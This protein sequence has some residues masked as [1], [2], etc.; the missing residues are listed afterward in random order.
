MMAQAFHPGPGL[1]PS[2][3]GV[4]HRV[5]FF[6]P[7]PPG[8]PDL[9]APH[10]SAPPRGPPSRPTPKPAP[11]PQ[12]QLLPF[13]GRSAE[14]TASPVSS[15]VSPASGGSRVVSPRCDQAPHDDQGFSSPV[16]V[17]AAPNLH[18]SLSL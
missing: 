2:G 11:S 6:F 9:T 8:P 7:E 18:P 3:P 4:E 13:P 16:V 12:I 1:S 14:L 15:P 5:V 10:G 17:S